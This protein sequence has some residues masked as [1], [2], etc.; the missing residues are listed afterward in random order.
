M[1]NNNRIKQ[2]SIIAILTC[3]ASCAFSNVD[4]D[5]N[6]FFGSLGYQDNVTTPSAYQGQAAG[7]YS[8]GSLYLRNQVKNYQ[9]ASIEL[10]SF[11]G[12]CSGIDAFLGSFSVISTAQLTSMMKNIMSSG[13]AYAF[14]L[15]LTT[16]VPQ[17]KTVKDYIQ[18]YVNDIN[19]ANINS[20]NTAEDLVGG[21][22]PK[23]QSSQQQICRDVGSHNGVFSDWAS[24]R[25]GCGTGG[26]FD[27]GIGDG[28]DRKSEVIVNKN[29]VWDALKNNGFT[30]TDTELSEMLM[31]LSGSIIIQNNNGKI[32]KTTLMSMAHSQDIIKAL[33]YGGQAKVYACDETNKCLNPT[34]QSIS[35]APNHGLVSQVAAMIM[36]LNSDVA[37][38]SGALDKA[39]I[40]FLEKTP[41]PVLK[42]ISN[43]LALGKAVNSNEFSDIIAISLLNQ[44]ISENIQ[45]VQLALSQEDTPMTPQMA[46]QISEAQQ[47]IAS[48]MADSYRK[49]SNINVLT[50]NIR[51]DEQQLTSR[52]A[53]QASVG[54]E[55]Q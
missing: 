47:L 28:G 9:L 48:K 2:A 46:T 23:T 33:M 19:S 16:T 27:Q 10:P 21:V 35:V 25:E 26:Q 55:T 37:S 6:N 12:G 11:A 34:I 50:N 1:I 30:A 15:A 13:G 7:Y 17:I 5:L 8:G 39:T 36:Q 40:G 42:Y 41:V 49:L 31:S 43:S 45:V 29:L 18:K 14:D 38:D 44:Y 4:S 3:S 52:L 20:C 22:W 54:Q 32:K 51:S 53:D 24:A